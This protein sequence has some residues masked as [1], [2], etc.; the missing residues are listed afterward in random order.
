MIECA[1]MLFSAGGL[2]GLLRTTDVVYKTAMYA[3]NVFLPLSDT[4]QN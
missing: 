3:E 4:P 1:A 2:Q